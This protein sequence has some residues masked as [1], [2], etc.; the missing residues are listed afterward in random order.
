MVFGQQIMREKIIDFFVGP[1]SGGKTEAANYA[2]NLISKMRTTVRIADVVYFV[3]LVTTDSHGEEGLREAGNHFHEWN[4]KS[5]FNP[6]NHAHGENHFPFTV[7][8]RE[9]DIGPRLFEA[10]GRA[11][12][13][14]TQKIE[15]ASLES[16]EPVGRVIVE[17]G[18]G[19]NIDCQ[20]SQADWSTNA[21]IEAWK[22]AGLWEEILPRIGRV[23][24]VNAL[25]EVRLGRNDLRPD[26]FG[27][28]RQS[29]AVGKECLHVTR[30]PDF[31]SW[32]E[33]GLGENQLIITEN[34][35]SRSDFHTSISGPFM[36]GLF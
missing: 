14:A 15:A 18:M 26:E 10:T 13:E 29:F 34:N 33:H 28:E 21:W 30:Q 22:R 7:I 36:E 25:W 9:P 17:A 11:I 5:F 19:L 35:G 1:F 6:H 12:V 20:I 23:F 16:G 2:E 24:A 32:L 31:K 27:G 4:Q 3:P 8:E